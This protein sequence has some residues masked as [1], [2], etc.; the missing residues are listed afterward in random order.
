MRRTSLSLLILALLVGACSSDDKPVDS[1]RL[2]LAIVSGDRQ[3]APVAAA[4]TVSGAALIPGLS[5]QTLP[6]NL[7]PEPLV[8]RIVV[9]GEPLKSLS[10]PSDPLGP[11]LVTLPSDVVVTYRVIQPT[12]VGQRHCG[13]S[14]VSSAKPDAD[15]LVTTYWERG[16]YAGECR[17]E[18]RLVIDGEPRVDTVFVAEFEPGPVVRLTH[19]RPSQDIVVQSGEVIDWRDLI[20]GG[21]DAHGNLIDPDVVRATVPDSLIR[22][23]WVDRANRM[24]RQPEQSGWT[25]TAPDFAADGFKESYT[26]TGYAPGLY[27]WHAHHMP[28]VLISFVSPL[29]GPSEQ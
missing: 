27:I 6:D 29:A 11:S 24:A 21:G 22:W 10:T 26:G 4:P 17:M 16:T 12:G 8:A 3:T 13:D 15:G 20:T 2:S 1:S 19:V 23:Q 25:I 9:D 7:L 18:V 5:L 28:L 14:F